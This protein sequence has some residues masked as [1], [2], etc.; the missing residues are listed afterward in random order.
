[1][2]GWGSVRA[3]QFLAE[4][5][6]YAR[7]AHASGWQ[8]GTHANRDVGIDKASRVYERLQGE[9]PRW[10]PRFRVERCYQHNGAGLSAI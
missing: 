5:Y 7:R 2:G 9:L 1:M 8:I 4:L 10:D 6:S 3:Y